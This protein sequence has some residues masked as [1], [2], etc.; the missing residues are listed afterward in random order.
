MALLAAALVGNYRGRFR[1][2]YRMKRRNFITAVRC[3][4]AS[5]LD[6]ATGLR[7]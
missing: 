4:M 6:Q 5:T 3:A 7:G 1:Q 2:K